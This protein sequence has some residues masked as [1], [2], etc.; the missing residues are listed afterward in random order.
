MAFFLTPWI[1][2]IVGWL[3]HV[4]LDKS[5][6]KKTKPRVIE[7]LLLWLL[8]VTGVMGVIGALGHL[9]PNSDQVA[10]E[11]GFAPSMFQWEVGWGDMALSVLLIGCAWKRHRGYWLTAAVVVLAIQY[12]GDAIGHIMQYSVHN[13]TAPNNVWAIPSDI[14]QPIIAIILLVIYRRFQKKGE[15]ET[16]EEPQALAS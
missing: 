16:P 1:V 3:V 11:I 13:N 14:L 9:G 10:A 6:I 15:L 4:S 2:T 7:L 5:S 12:G 8:V